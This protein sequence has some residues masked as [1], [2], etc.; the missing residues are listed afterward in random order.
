MEAID[1]HNYEPWAKRILEQIKNNKQITTSNRETIQTYFVYMKNQAKGTKEENGLAWGTIKK[2]LESLQII[3]TYF[4]KPFKQAARKDIETVLTALE[5]RTRKGQLVNGW[6]RIKY[7]ATIKRFFKWLNGDED[8]P[9]SVRWIKN[10]KKKIHI[11]EENQIYTEEDIKKIIDSCMHPRDKC[12]V[13]LGYEGLCRIGEIGSLT[14]GKVVQT[15]KNGRGQIVISGKTGARAIF[16]EF[17]IPYIRAWLDCHPLRN[18]PEFEA[19]PLFV[20]LKEPRK[21]EAM[22]YP[23]I[24][25]VIEQAINRAG[26]KKEFKNPHLVFR[27][28]RASYWANLGASERDLMQLGGWTDSKSVGVYIAKR[29]LEKIQNRLLGREKT[30]VKPTILEPIKCKICGELNTPRA[31]ECNRCFN[32]LNVVIAVRIQQTKDAEMAMLREEMKMMQATMQQLAQTL[33]K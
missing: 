33:K 5:S 12:L 32:P 1:I 20:N 21:F 15:A 26:I 19:Q 30:E 28:S 22:G 9:E 4:K 10:P 13:A 18:N 29:D 27:K 8:Y 23:G 2:N 16:A 6:T 31:E 17:S 25:K 3:G 11:L 14:I 24:K 7:R